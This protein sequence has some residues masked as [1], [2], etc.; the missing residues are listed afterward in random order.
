MQ[1]LP[2]ALHATILDII[3]DEYD[4]VEYDLQDNRPLQ[5][6]YLD[7]LESEFSFRNALWFPLGLMATELGLLLPPLEGWLIAAVGWLLAS[8]MKIQAIGRR[9]EVE[10]YLAE[11]IYSGRA[12]PP[13]FGSLVKRYSETNMR[14]DAKVGEYRRAGWVFNFLVGRGAAN[15]AASGFERCWP[16]GHYQDPEIE[17]AIRELS[18]DSVRLLD[19]TIGTKYPALRARAREDRES[20]P[21]HD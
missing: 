8:V 2:P 17:V 16:L 19:G 15:Y 18:P 3:V 7:R 5:Y 21:I 6:D 4:R 13:L 1:G 9:Q 10:T 12:F 20:G 11:S 14:D